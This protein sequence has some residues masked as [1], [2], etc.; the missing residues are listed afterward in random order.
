M[1]PKRE[2]PTAP[3]ADTV[4][5][6]KATENSKPRP[7]TFPAGPSRPIR[8]RLAA[9]LW[10]QHTLPQLS[11]KKGHLAVAL[12]SSKGHRWKWFFAGMRKKRCRA[13]YTQSVVT[14]TTG[15]CPKREL[16]TIPH[17]GIVAEKFDLL[18]ASGLHSLRRGIRP[19]HDHEPCAATLSPF[20]ANGTPMALRDRFHQC[21]PEAHTT[22]F[23]A[24]T[25]Q[26]VEGFKNLLSQLRWHT[27]PA[28]FHAH[29][30]P[31]TDARMRVR[32]APR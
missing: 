28:V 18:A 10:P 23:F 24:R 14:A 4:Y 11:G 13:T 22:F 17:L 2:R 20:A 9:F 30:G 31:C 1:W 8:P 32:A 7:L 12:K 6:L 19:E 3:I 16:L 21:Q 27:R 26:P 29:L 25:G 15:F 5:R